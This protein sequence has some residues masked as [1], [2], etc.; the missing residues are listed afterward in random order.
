MDKR[1]VYLNE[2]ALRYEQVIRESNKKIEGKFMIST[3]VM[4]LLEVP[5]MEFLLVIQL[6]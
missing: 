1:L 5:G 6:N 2:W 4:Q 3:V